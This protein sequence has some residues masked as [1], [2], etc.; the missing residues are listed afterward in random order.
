MAIVPIF[1]GTVSESGMLSLEETERDLRRAHFGGLAGQ[2][3]EVIIRKERTKRSLDQNAFIHAVPVT[4]LAGHFGES[5]PDM[6]LILMG[7]CWGWR[8]D[9]I[10]GREIPIKAH[11]SDMTVEECTY[12]IDWVIPWAMVEHGVS[13]P[14]PSEAEAA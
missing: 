14:L 3:V 4:I 6:K 5:M 9:P 2:R 10:A 11:T 12:F 7:E 1:H 8:F 13:I